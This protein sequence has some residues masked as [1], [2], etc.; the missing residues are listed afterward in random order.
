MR[1]KNASP[2]GNDPRLKKP[3]VKITPAKLGLKRVVAE[4]GFE[5]TKTD[6]DEVN[7]SM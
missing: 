4:Q 5:L 6:L 7:L 2:K 3:A 1:L